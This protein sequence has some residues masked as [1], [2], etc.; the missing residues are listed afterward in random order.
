[1]AQIT[2]EGIESRGLTGFI[3]LVETAFRSALGQE[4]SLAAETPQ[5][6]LIGEL[7][8]VLTEAEELAEY[9]AN[10]LSLHN[11]QKRQLAD[12][13]TLL[14]LAKIAGERSSV[15]ATL[16]G[17][18][19]TIIPAG[20]R[21][22]NT[23]GS[24]F[25]TAARVTIP[26]GGSIDVL[27]RSVETGPFIAAAGTL[28]QI[29]DARAGWTGVTNSKDALLG[30]NLESDPEYRRRYT[31]E[32]AT[33]ARDD[34]EAIRARILSEDGVTDA[35]VRDNDTSASVTVHGIAIP[36]GSIL[37]VVKGG[38]DQDVARA[39][40]L[41]KPAGAPT[42]GKR[43]VAWTHA[44]GFV[45]NVKFSRVDPIPIEVSAPLTALPS[46]PSNGLATMRSNLLHWFAGTW[47]VPGPG[48]FDQTGVGIGEIIDL[49]RLNTPL[50]AVPGHVL[51]KVVVERKAGLLATISVTAG[52]SNYTSADVA[53]AGSSGATAVAVISNGAVVRVDI[54]NRGDGTLTA[55]PA[56]TF[57]GGGGTGATATSTISAAAL[58]TPDLDQQYTLDTD[59]ITLTLSVAPLLVAASVNGTALV[60]TYNLPLNTGSVP[61][62]GDMEVDVGG[63]A[64]TV[65]SVAV[66]GN[67]VTITLAAA[68]SAGDVVKVSYTPGTNPLEDPSG[69]NVASL[70]DEAVVNNTA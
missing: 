60:L 25:A 32:V 53:I 64:V 17:T 27:M 59:D 63:S 42:T 2:T 34:V 43:T 30:R 54:T 22:R 26:A 40:A 39:I 21:V 57:S 52:G 1:M 9:V 28:T 14:S 68:V 67:K 46:F 35:L 5:G 70:M 24:V 12:W 29:V 58:E 66:D 3:T 45:V 38:A 10:G 8:E 19:G 48:I 23:L 61:A 37:S 51:G 36:A 55:A 50:N 11:A 31:N 20:S 15:T 47:P 7:G 4:L 18:S 33:H 41:T 62:T 16:T 56:I 65:S 13:G 44:Q 49:E 6:Q 69:N